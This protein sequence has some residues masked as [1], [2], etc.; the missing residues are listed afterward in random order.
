M[1]KPRLAAVCGADSQE[2][3]TVF[4]LLGANRRSDALLWRAPQINVCGGYSGQE[5]MRPRGG[6]AALP[7]SRGKWSHVRPRG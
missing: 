4:H 7:Q 1:S 2:K 3:P 6:L 5:A